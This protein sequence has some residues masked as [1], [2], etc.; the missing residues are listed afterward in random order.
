ME[1]GAG[2]ESVEFGQTQLL[3]CPTRSVR[4]G[5]HALFVSLKTRTAGMGFAR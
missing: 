5:T 1:V 3:F 2:V 4:S